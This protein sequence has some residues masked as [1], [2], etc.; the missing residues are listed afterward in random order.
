M[1][2]Q[3]DR[4]CFSWSRS[5]TFFVGQ[6]HD[7]TCYQILHLIFNCIV[8]VWYF[9]FDTFFY[10]LS[11][12]FIIIPSIISPASHASCIL[13]LNHPLQLVARHSNPF[14]LTFPFKLTYS[15]LH[16]EESRPSACF[17]I[18]LLLICFQSWTQILN[19]VS[20]VYLAFLLSEIKEEHIRVG[21]FF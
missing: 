12:S 18:V 8:R 21:F 3:R 16:L 19:S 13:F 14:L 4:S 10:K 15:L 11:P 1:V 7:V 6:V 2:R 5:W 9:L 20:L 17:S